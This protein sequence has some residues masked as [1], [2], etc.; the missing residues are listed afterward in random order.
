MNIVPFKHDQKLEQVSQ[1]LRHY[2]PVF[3]QEDPNIFC[4][5]AP[6]IFFVSLVYQLQD[7]GLRS[8]CRL[9]IEQSETLI[10]T[11]AKAIGTKL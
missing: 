6:M 1:K 4:L 11:P 8:L 2:F 10:M 5:V 7:D 9:L 3:G